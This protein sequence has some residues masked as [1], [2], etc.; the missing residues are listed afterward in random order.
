MAFTPQQQEFVE[1]LPKGPDFIDSN[2][3]R[4]SLQATNVQQ[5]D[6]SNNLVS[7]AWRCTSNATSN[8]YSGVSGKWFITQ[9][10][11][12]VNGT[13][14]AQNESWAG[15]PPK[16]DTTYILQGPDNRHNGS[17]A[18]LDDSNQ[19]TLSSDD[20]GCTGSNDSDSSTLWYSQV[21]TQLKDKAQQL[22]FTC[23]QQ[24]SVALAY[25]NTSQFINN[26]CPAGF[27]CKFNILCGS[28]RD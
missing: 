2:Q 23:L 22:R 28:L 26:G 11:P 27:F 13:D 3:C 10:L 24:G 20:Q 21:Q 25:G 12:N 7:E 6:S 14:L 17:L 8:P 4:C 9:N 16:L 19:N 1:G 18:P 5:S 15:N